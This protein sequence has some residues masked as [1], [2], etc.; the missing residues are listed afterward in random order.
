MTADFMWTRWWL[1]DNGTVFK[2]EHSALKALPVPAKSAREG[3]IGVH[4]ARFLP[5][6]LSS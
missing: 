2:E 5:Y 4:S 3:Q 6:R 1:E